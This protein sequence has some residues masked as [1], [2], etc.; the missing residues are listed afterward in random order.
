MVHRCLYFMEGVYWD[1][2]NTFPV[3]VRPLLRE[4]KQNQTKEIR[5]TSSSTRYKIISLRFLFGCAGYINCSWKVCAYDDHV[6]VC[7]KITCCGIYLS[8]Q[9][10]NHVTFTNSEINYNTYAF[11][12]LLRGL[13]VFTYTICFR[14]RLTQYYQY[15]WDVY[16]NANRIRVLYT[17]G[18]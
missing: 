5:F 13:L 15:I 1:M 4:V 6:M 16:V 10:Y 11:N 12:H 18:T 3:A 14:E 17:T 8:V 2:H 7:C 9:Q